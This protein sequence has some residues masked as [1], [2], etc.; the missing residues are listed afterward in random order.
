MGQISVEEGNYEYNY[1]TQPQAAKLS[2]SMYK[3]VT[4][5]SDLM[6]SYAADTASVFW[7]IFGGE[8]T[9]FLQNPKCNIYDF[10]V[11]SEWTTETCYRYL[12]NVN[13]VLRDTIGVYDRSLGRYGWSQDTCSD[14]YY[15]RPLLYFK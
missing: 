7:I 13:C 3:S 12:P 6:N 4:F 15:F 5:E 1:V 11:C 9:D 10:N 14:K 2:Q 8:E